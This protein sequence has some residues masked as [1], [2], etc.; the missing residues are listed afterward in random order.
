MADKVLSVVATVASRLPDLSIKDGQL[1]FCQDK[2]KIAFDYKGK[3]VFYNQV[4]TLETEQERKDI[5][6]P[7][8][9]LFYFVL[10]TATLWTYKNGWIQLTTP[11]EEIVFIGITL[12]ALGSEKTL[13]VNKTE[14][15]ISVWDKEQS[16]YVIVGEQITSISEDDISSLFV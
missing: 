9:E 1:T 14:K 4:V 3:R 5:L 13:Y 16:Q 8:E 11:P 10:G 12:P 15:N 6:A 7:I 2:K